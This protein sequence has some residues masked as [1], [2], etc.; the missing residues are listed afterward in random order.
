MG[1]HTNTSYLFFADEPPYGSEHSFNAPP[2]AIALLKQQEVSVPV[3]F[4]GDASGA[5]IVFWR[6]Q[7]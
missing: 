5:V 4:L 7:R 2:W 3:F 1:H 6:R